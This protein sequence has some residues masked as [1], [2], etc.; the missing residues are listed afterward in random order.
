MG[1]RLSAIALEAGE[2]ISTDVINVDR[3]I[4]L[5]DG[6]G[7]TIWTF[8]VTGLVGLLVAKVA[9]L[10]GRNKHKDAYD[11]VWLLENWQGGPEGAAAAVLATGLL[12]RDDVRRAMDRLGAEF[13]A[14][15]RLGPGSFVHFIAPAGAL[16]DD[17]IRLARQAAGAIAAFQ[18]SLR[19]G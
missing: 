12:G 1:P 8:R 4:T 10:V 18:D 15:D 5:P 7:R 11:I 13:A 2:A 19:R 16:Q 9:A 3:E 14:P 17:R 6:G